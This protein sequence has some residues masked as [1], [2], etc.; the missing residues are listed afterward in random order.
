MSV[1]D[2]E[3]AEVEYEKFCK[4]WKIGRKVKRMNAEELEQYDAQK[5][6]ILDCIMD[7]ML[8]LDEHDVLQ[9]RMDEPVSGIESV[10]IAKPNFRVMKATDKYG[11]NATTSKTIALI[12]AAT[13]QPE[14]LV[15]LFDWNTDVTNIMA[16]LGH[17]LS[18]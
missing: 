5:E 6:I 4:A 1:V 12:A 17:F 3:T 14:K 8:S 16:V 7:G 18:A 2:R 13:K 11:D 15:E 10:S 9:Y